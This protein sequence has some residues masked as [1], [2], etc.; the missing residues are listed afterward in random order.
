[1]SASHCYSFHL[2]WEI[3]SPETKS[4]QTI[5]MITF[6]GRTF[7]IQNR[8]NLNFDAGTQSTTHAIF[9]RNFKVDQR[10]EICEKE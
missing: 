8:R 9:L 2:T 3:D 6:D 1:M 7:A 4:D 10:H 5:T